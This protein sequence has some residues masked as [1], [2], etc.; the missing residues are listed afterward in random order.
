MVPNEAIWSGFGKIL[1]CLADVA[2]IPA[3]FELTETTPRSMKHRNGY[4]KLCS[5]MWAVNPLSIVI[6]SRGSCD[7]L[8]NCLLLW[9]LN[10][11]KR[12]QNAKNTLFG[13]GL[14]FGLLIHFRLYPVIYVPAFFF[15]LTD[16]HIYSRKQFAT[17]FVGTM[18]SFAY[19]TSISAVCD[20]RF[21]QEGIMYHFFRRDHRHNFSAYFYRSYLMASAE[22][23]ACDIDIFPLSKGGLSL[24]LT[25]FVLQFAIIIVLAARLARRH[26]N[27][28]LLLSTMVFVAYNKVITTQYFTWYACLV[29]LILPSLW[30]R[31]LQPHTRQGHCSIDRGVA[32]KCSG[33]ALACLYTRNT[34][35]QYLSYGALRWSCISRF[36][37]RTHRFSVLRRSAMI[38]N[39]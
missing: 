7:S 5:L 26:L 1:F 19:F 16:Q 9:M 21:V 36:S 14:A 25:P 17:F 10:S 24:F 8:S 13:V 33:V 27:L 3:I 32:L 37:R 18:M 39:F 28:T 23:H 12:I 38:Q 30:Q 4:G 6:C 34:S 2:M 15:H 20:G 31:P 11:M 35:S 22:S 29:P